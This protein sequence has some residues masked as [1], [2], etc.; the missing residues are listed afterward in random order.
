MTSDIGT[1][2]RERE[3][4]MLIDILIVLAIIAVAM[5]ILRGRFSRT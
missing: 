1:D 4:I 2:A 5:Y 3:P